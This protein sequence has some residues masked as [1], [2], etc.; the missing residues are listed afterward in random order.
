MANT[1]GVTYTDDVFAE[2][3][4]EIKQAADAADEKNIRDAL[5]VGAREFTD[6]LLKLPYPISQVRKAGYTHMVD[7]FTYTKNKQGDGF[8]VG[9]GKYYGMIQEVGSKEFRAQPHFYPLWEKNKRRY[10]NDSISR[11]G[12]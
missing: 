6:D 10:Y 8:V 3:Q 2:L 1:R 4:R 5:E 12:L 11:L 9:W 7:S